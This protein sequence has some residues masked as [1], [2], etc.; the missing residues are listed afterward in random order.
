MKTLS[1]IF[2]CHF[3]NYNYQISWHRSGVSSNYWIV[4]V[5]I[6][7]LNSSILL[8]CQ[9]FH[10]QNGTTCPTWMNLLVRI[11]QVMCSRPASWAF[12]FKWRRW[13]AP[14]VSFLIVC[15]SLMYVVIL[16]CFE[17]TLYIN[18]YT[19]IGDYSRRNK[20]KHS[21]SD[22][23]AISSISPP[24]SQAI[25]LILKQTQNSAQ[26]WFYIWVY[27]PCWVYY[28]KDSLLIRKVK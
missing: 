12:I 2:P 8:I 23:Y 3:S 21:S 9:N 26:K 27:C 20:R 13:I 7:I 6:A 16:S 18:Y 5:C 1:L 25:W 11:N 4:F 28:K 10:D 19:R 24:A 15:T 17:Y 22:S 14:K